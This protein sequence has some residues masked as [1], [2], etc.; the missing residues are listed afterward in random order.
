MATM[1]CKLKQKP[2][3]KKKNIIE[4]VPSVRTSLFEI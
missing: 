2:L 3:L 1:L 4:R